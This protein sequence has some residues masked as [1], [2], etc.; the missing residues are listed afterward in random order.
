MGCAPHR[1]H[2]LPGRGRVAQVLRTA[3]E[4]DE[5]AAGFGLVDA[6]AA[7]EAHVARLH[8]Q[9]VHSG[10]VTHWDIGVVPA[11][12]A[13]TETGVLN[14]RAAGGNGSHS[15]ARQCELALTV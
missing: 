10:V 8:A 12:P 9:A 14:M 5:I 13:A 11:G 2:H 7:L 1:P 4:L 3:P 15:E 6:R